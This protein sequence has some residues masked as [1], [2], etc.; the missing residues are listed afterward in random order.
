MKKNILFWLILTI[1]F[2]EGCLDN[3]IKN[4]V[5][6][7]DD[8]KQQ[9]IENESTRLEEQI[10]NNHLYRDYYWDYLYLAEKAIKEKDYIHLAELFD[11][12]GVRFFPYAFE[13]NWNGFILTKSAVLN[14]DKNTKYVRWIYDWSWFPIEKT[15]EEYF[16]EFVGENLLNWW[17][18]EHTAEEMKY[19][20]YNSPDFERLINLYPDSLFASY[21][22]EWHEEYDFMDRESLY[23][24]LKPIMWENWIKE[25]KIVSIIHD[26]HTM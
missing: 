25:R 1:V 23:I 9:I 20:P 19:R 22:D 3:K 11:D 4:E 17:R 14:N 10:E 18:D 2:L 8:S 12:D 16:D 15:I 21:Y 24:V 7:V 6:V 13:V 26:Q 5:L